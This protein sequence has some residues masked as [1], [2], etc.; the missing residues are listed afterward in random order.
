M[1]LF[2][3]LLIA[4]LPL[5]MA[6]A[7]PASAQA[8]AA[9]PAPTTWIGKKVLDP[10]EGDVGMVTAFKQG[11]V[12]VKT[13]KHEASLPPTSFT[14]QKGKLYL[15]MTRA[16]LNGEMDKIV[17]ASAASLAVGATVKGSAGS[18]VGTIETIDE[19]YVTIKLASGNFVKIPRSGIVGTPDGAVIGVTVEALEAQLAAGGQN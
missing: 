6:V 1:R 12:V 13:D 9:Q 11:M 7:S 10:K 2:A 16:E 15:G 8:Q 4:A 18:A 14:Y 3:S 19:Q 5:T 17:E